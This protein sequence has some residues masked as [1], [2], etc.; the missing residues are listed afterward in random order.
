M[1]TAIAK[2]ASD[3]LSPQ[4]FDALIRRFTRAV[5]STVKRPERQALKAAIA[6]LKGQR[7]DKLTDAQ[8]TKAIN[9]AAGKLG[10]AAG[11]VS[12]A[13]GRVVSAQSIAVLQATKRAMRDGHKLDITATLNAADKRVVKYAG[14]SQAHFVRNE[15]GQREVAF[16]KHARAIVSQGIDKG[17]DPKEIG[18]ALES[19]LGAAGLRRAESYWRVVASIHSTRARSYGQVRSFQ[20]AQIGLMIFTAVLDE[21]TTE[22][23]RFMHNKVFSTDSAANRYQQVAES[24]DPES[25]VDLQPFIQSGKDPDTGQ[26]V[27][28]AKRNGQRVIVAHVDTPGVGVRDGVGSYSRAM[29]PSQIESMGSSTPPLHGL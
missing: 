19:Q 2:A 5:T 20:D 28:Y 29:T 21:A 1:I 8:L 24:G 18:R 25:V 14:T 12:I 16:S 4:G 7:W 22:Q 6:E 17:F 3:P 10:A 15:F 27:L 23:C 26:Q 13:V 9:K 11:P